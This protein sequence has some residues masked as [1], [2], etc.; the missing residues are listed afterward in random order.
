[1]H[2]GSERAHNLAEGEAEAAQHKLG[3]FS[4]S[5]PS[6]QKIENLA[7]QPLETVVLELKTIY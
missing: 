6:R 3:A 2:D 5:G 1:L 7:D 4:W